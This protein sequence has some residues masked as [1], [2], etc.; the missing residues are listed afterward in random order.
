MVPLIEEVLPK[1]YRI[2]V[3]LPESPLRSVNSYVLKGK[4]RNIIIDTGM[5]KRVRDVMDAALK[6]LKVDR[7]KQISL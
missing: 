3:P 4:E 6:V 1:I 2:E 7:I 5:N